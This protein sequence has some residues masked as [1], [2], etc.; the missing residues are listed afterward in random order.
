MAGSLPLTHPLHYHRPLTH[1]YH[2]IPRAPCRWSHSVQ[3]TTRPSTNLDPC[4]RGQ[5]QLSPQ[6]LPALLWVG[7]DLTQASHEP[8]SG[9]TTPD[10]VRSWVRRTLHNTLDAATWDGKTHQTPSTPPATDECWVSHCV[11]S[12]SC[13]QS[14]IVG[15][16]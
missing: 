7:L 8:L 3:L 15:V 9:L 2:S 11:V 5:L 16:T 10:A 12:L 14:P 4:R 1:C 13:H 6:I